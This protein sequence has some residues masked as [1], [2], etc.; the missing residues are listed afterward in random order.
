MVSMHHSLYGHSIV[1][2]C[3]AAVCLIV[4]PTWLLNPKGGFILSILAAHGLIPI[5]I[6]LWQETL[7]RERD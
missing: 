6:I 3:R 4:Q 5:L 7:Q 1:V 2:I